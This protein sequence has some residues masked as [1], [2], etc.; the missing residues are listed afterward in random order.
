MRAMI[1]GLS[2]LFSAVAAEAQDDGRSDSYCARVTAPCLRRP[3]GESMA[4]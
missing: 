2:V 3:Y 1:L 4:R